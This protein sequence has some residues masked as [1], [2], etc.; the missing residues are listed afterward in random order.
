MK[1]Q[2]IYVQVDGLDALRVEASLLSRLAHHFILLLQEYL[3]YVVLQIGIG[4]ASSVHT[5]ASAVQEVY[6][7]L[8]GAF[9]GL[10][11]CVLPFLGSRAKVLFAVVV[12][13]DLVAE[14]GDGM[15]III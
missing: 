12:Y 7:L 14:V 13:C 9:F 1:P 2:V 3:V 4:T 6:L 8:L 11:A 15:C 10:G 5:L